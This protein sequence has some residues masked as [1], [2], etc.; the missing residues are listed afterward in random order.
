MV[1]RAN[2]SPLKHFINEVYEKGGN[3]MQ[4]VLN[5]LKKPWI[6]PVGTIA[7]FCVFYG[8]VGI[9]VAEATLRSKVTSGSGDELVEALDK[10]GLTVV[11]ILRQLA[12]VICVLVAMSMGYSLWIKKTAEGLADVK[13]RAGALAGGL[14]FVFFA[15]KIIG[16]LLK[17]FGYEGTV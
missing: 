3:N 5:F 13:G 6:I 16:T 11:D 12:M 2:H 4:V 1:I 10:A 8:F 7:A 15:E 17:V 9:E 14:F